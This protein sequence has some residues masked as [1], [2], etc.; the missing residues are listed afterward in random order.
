[1]PEK[2]LVLITVQDWEI[3]DSKRPD[4]SI[5]KLQWFTGGELA[6]DLDDPSNEWA[7]DIISTIIPIQ[8]VF[9]F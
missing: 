7:V 3:L 6:I 4:D 5:L 2:G 9:E 1:M 8:G